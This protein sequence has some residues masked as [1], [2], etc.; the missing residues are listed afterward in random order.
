[1]TFLHSTSSTPNLLRKPHLAVH[2]IQS[3]STSPSP[4][5]LPPSSTST[6][7]SAATPDLHSGSNLSR[8]S[9]SEAG[10]S[11]STGTTQRSHGVRAHLA[12][13]LPI[14][15]HASFSVELTI[16]QL[17]NV[18]LVSGDFSTRWKFQNVT[19]A[20]IGQGL[21][22]KLNSPSGNTVT[23]AS[24]NLTTGKGKGKE[25][26]QDYDDS[27]RQ[28]T[29]TSDNVAYLLSQSQ[30]ADSDN[31]ND[32]LMPSGA[33]MLSIPASEGSSSSQSHSYRSYSQQS[34]NSQNSASMSSYP[35]PRVDSFDL[36]SNTEDI[37]SDARTSFNIN[38]TEGTST[39]SEGDNGLGN[40]L[41]PNTRLPNGFSISNPTDTSSPAS[42]GSHS[43]ESRGR[44]PYVPL[45]E[46]NVKWN[47]NVRI[48]AVQIGVSRDANRMLNPCELKL[49]V[50]QQ[51]CI[52]HF[53]FLKHNAYLIYLF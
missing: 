10:S 32:V 46:H 19:R 28:S 36:P 20:R 7:L 18:P 35:S 27:G 11:T 40:E 8:N 17:W 15:R 6:P 22:R 3:M 4:S 1:M 30:T 45:R 31:E 51:V 52:F 29:S 43:T 53:L 42:T 41:T 5:S 25:I 26:S 14:T 24:S 2:G 49:V 37:K 34:Q 38:S 33:S 12:E 44:T 21:N 23:N 47:H 13:L 48:G 39:I 16:H 9:N 50:E